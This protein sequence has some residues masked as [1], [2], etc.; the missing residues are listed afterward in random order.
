MSW[1]LLMF[2]FEH[3]VGENKNVLH[4]RDYSTCKNHIFI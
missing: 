2:H 3:V 4:V 1:I